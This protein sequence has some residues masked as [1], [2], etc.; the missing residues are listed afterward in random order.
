VIARSLVFLAVSCASCDRYA[1]DLR[2]GKLAE[3]AHPTLQT[4]VWEQKYVL[5]VSNEAADHA[6]LVLA[7]LSAKVDGVPQQLTV[8]GGRTSGQHKGDFGPV[9]KTD[10]CEAATFAITRGK[11]VTKKSNVIEVT[12]GATTLKMEAPNV[13]V[14]FAWVKPPPSVAHPG[15]SIVV[16]VAPAVQRGTGKYDPS[17]FLV[18]SMDDGTTNLGHTVLLTPRLQTDGSIAVDLPADL[19]AGPFTFFLISNEESIAVL[20]CGAASC[21]TAS[22]FT[23]SAPVAIVR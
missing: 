21:T 2:P 12:D 13:I 17:N 19:H 6:C 8:A 9:D 22:E 15:D 1:H 11:D 7:N 10:Y 18:A 4:Y 5:S 23:L 16:R 3:V 14:D 20:S